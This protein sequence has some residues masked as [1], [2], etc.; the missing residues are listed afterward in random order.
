MARHT[1]EVMPAGERIEAEENSVLSD[2]LREHGIPL[3]LDCG[4]HGLCGK[5]LV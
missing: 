4:G 5:C 1:I 2:V 3:R